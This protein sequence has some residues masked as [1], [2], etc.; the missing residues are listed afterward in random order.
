MAKHRTLPR[1]G[2]DFFAGCTSVSRLIETYRPADVG[3]YNDYL[4][5]LAEG[6]LSAALYEHVRALREDTTTDDFP[7]LLAG[8]VD[9]VL[10]ASYGAVSQ[11]WRTCFRSGSFSNFREQTLLDLLELEADDELGNAADNNL[12]PKVPENH[13][14]NDMGLSETHEHATLATYGATFTLSRQMLINDDRRGFQRLPELMGKIAARTINWHVVNVL[15]AGATTSVSGQTMN[16]TYNLFETSAS[17]AH[18]GNMTSSALPLAAAAVKAEIIKFGAQKAPNGLTMD[19]LGIK[20]KYLIV[21]AALELTAREIVSNAS[22][23]GA[24]TTVQTSQNL[25]TFLTVVCIPELTSSKDWYLSADPA[26]YPTIEVAYLDGKESPDLMIQQ[27]G[28][29]NLSEADGQ[30]YKVR[31]DFVAYAA[32]WSAMRKVDD[33]T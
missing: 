6:R 20:P 8:S 18:H 27:T 2:D 26:D 16:D 29:V 17:G 28:T 30:R 24:G 7:T 9:T 19:V 23:I 15:E 5:M 31:E 1:V 11:P 33:T 14:F 13:G 25:L 3:R 4:A 10:R 22:L 32:G 21:P 12:L